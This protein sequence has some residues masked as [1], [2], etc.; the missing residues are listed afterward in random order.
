MP[1]T[2]LLVT[3]S[4]ILELPEIFTAHVEHRDECKVLRLASTRDGDVVASRAARAYRCYSAVHVEE[5]RADR[6]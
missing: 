1:P 5:Y 2:D 3:P 6:A 4:V